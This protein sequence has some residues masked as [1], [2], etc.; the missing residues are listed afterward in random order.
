MEEIRARAPRR[1]HPTHVPASCALDSK[2]AARAA[3]PPPPRAGGPGTS[4]PSFRSLLRRASARPCPLRPPHCLSVLSPPGRAPPGLGL[5]SGLPAAPGCPARRKPPVQELPPPRRPQPTARPDARG[6]GQWPD[7][8]AAYGVPCGEVNP[9]GRRPLV[10]WCPTLARGGAP[11]QLGGAE[12]CIN[13]VRSWEWG[14]QPH[15]ESDGGRGGRE[16]IAE[17]SK[18][19]LRRHRPRCREQHPK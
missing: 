2:P 13:P 10:T 9:K 19:K 1:P 6:G 11:S 5:A 4:Q 8:I 7:R 17:R 14:I 18:V 15:D 16:N 12:F 3:Q